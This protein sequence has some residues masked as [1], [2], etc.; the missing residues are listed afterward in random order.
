M[1][2]QVAKLIELD[3]D[4][5]LQKTDK[6]YA[7]RKDRLTASAVATALG[8]NKYKKPEALILTKCGYG[9]FKGNAATRH[10][11]KYEDVARKLY[12]DMYDEKVHELGIIPHATIDFLA[13]SPDGVT[14]TGRLVEIKC[15]MSRKI[16]ADVPEHYMPQLQLL[17]EIL[18][19]EVCDFIQYKPQEITFP[20]PSEFVVVSVERDRNWFT[21]N[22]PIMRGFWDRVLWYR[23]HG[24]DK[25][26]EE[27]EK[28]KRG[29]RKKKDPPPPVD[30]VCD[31]KDEEANTNW[32][33][34]EEN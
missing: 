23:E 4:G 14:E 34:V 18:D 24:C 27:K 19:L 25:L 15:P 11:D 20:G 9:E 8:V 17:M 7:L 28:R 10:G 22:L 26:L 30:V 3:K 1:H 33:E 21:E 16:E 31:I 13:G 2:K 5:P 6:W 32:W 29:P 12:E